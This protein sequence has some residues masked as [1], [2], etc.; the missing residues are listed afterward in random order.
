M[1]QKLIQDILFDYLEQTVTADMTLEMSERIT[2]AILMTREGAGLPKEG[3]ATNFSDAEIAGEQN[4]EPE[5]EAPKEEIKPELHE[6]PKG[7]KAVIAQPQ[8]P[9]KP[10]V[11]PKYK[12]KA[13]ISMPYGTPGDPDE[14]MPFGIKTKT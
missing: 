5:P 3:T 14:T 8:P 13:I 9:K 1:M 2:K 11:K 6:G 12:T 4:K 7:T 10:P